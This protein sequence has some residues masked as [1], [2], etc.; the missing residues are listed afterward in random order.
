[1]SMMVITE[2]GGSVARITA[3][4]DLELRQGLNLLYS[5]ARH[6]DAT[7][8]V[9]IGAN[10]GSYTVLAAL[11]PGLT[12]HAFEPHPKALAGLRE[13]ITRNNLG[14]RVTVHP[15]ALL[16]KEGT[17]TLTSPQ[18][19]RELGLA[20]LAPVALEGKFVKG[21]QIE[22]EVKTLDTSPVGDFDILKMDVEGAEL[23]ALQGGESKIRQC[24]PAILAEVQDKRTK[25]FG[26]WSER[27][28]KLLE[29]WGYT[30]L[31]IT[32]RDVF[33]WKRDEHNPA[34]WYDRKAE[35]CLQ[36]ARS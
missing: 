3:Y 23:M 30:A 16:D 5:L 32:K 6:A 12:V 8:M 27:I 1:M 26:Y 19:T 24:L 4:T 21:S 33:F 25:P 2:P 22:V 20:T 18:R 29:S 9:D 31:R 28:T 14:D 11:V 35:R 7:V 36:F 10:V 15:Y 17:A 34:H 13:N